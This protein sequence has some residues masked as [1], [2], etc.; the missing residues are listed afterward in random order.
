MNFLL[1]FTALK[2]SFLIKIKDCEK[3]YYPQAET[4]T[5]KEIDE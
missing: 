3:S 1:L 4:M 5:M 2:D